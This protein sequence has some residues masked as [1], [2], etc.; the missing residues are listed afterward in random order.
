MGGRDH[1]KPQSRILAP[2]G[3]LEW[4]DG[5]PH[6]HA[7]SLVQIGPDIEERLL[8]GVDDLRQLAGF[9]ADCRQIRTASVSH[10]FL[11]RPGRIAGFPVGRD[12]LFELGNLIHGEPPAGFAGPPRRH[13]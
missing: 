9:D 11:R 6:D 3:S 13:L 2:I 8:G 10:A 12:Q 1:R 4:R 5:G 7:A